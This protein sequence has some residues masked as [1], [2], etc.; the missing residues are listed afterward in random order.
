MLSVPALSAHMQ[1][2]AV[3]EKTSNSLEQL[4]DKAWKLKGTAGQVPAGSIYVFLRNGTL[5]ETSCVETY[6]IATWTADRK[7]AR[8][9]QVV[10]DGQP[11]F[12]ARII[13]LTSTTLR[14][15]QN[16]IRSKEKREMTLTAVEQE[17]V[18]PDLRK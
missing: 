15:Q 5:L 12:A 18:C 11:A 9:L 2:A 6:R 7:A 4:F 16:L 17:S 8:T 13:E 3:N 10:E 14:M 1:H